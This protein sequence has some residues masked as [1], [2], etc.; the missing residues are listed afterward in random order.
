MKKKVGEDSASDP[1]VSP[2]KRE[3][4][5]SVSWKSAGLVWIA[6]FLFAL[7]WQ[8]QSGAWKSDFGGHA[9]EAAHVVT[10]LMVRDYLAGGFLEEWHPMRFA[11]AYYERFPKVAIGH[12]P[13]GFYVIEAL[14][15]LP[16]RQPAAL[17]VLM[18]ALAASVGWQTWRLARD[19]GIDEW[20]A[21]ALGLLLIWLPLVRTYTAIVMSDLLLV[22]LILAATRAFAR[23]LEAERWRDSWMFGLLAA[24]AILTKGSG[25]LLALVPPLAIAFSGRWSLLKSPRLWVAPV[26]VLLLAFPWM[27]ATRHI[28]EEGMSAIPFREYVSSALAS[29]FPGIVHEMGWLATALAVMALLSLAGRRNRVEIESATLWALVI[30]LLMF[31]LAIPSG[32]DLRYLL[33]LLPPLLVLAGSCLQRLGGRAFPRAKTWAVFALVL[34]VVWEVRRP[35]EKRYV[36]AAAAVERLL[37]ANSEAERTDVLVVS[38]ASG[39]G[40]ITAAA[41]FRAPHR[42]RVDRGSK[43]LAASDWLGRGYEKKFEDAE[44]LRTILRER[45]T[46]FVI[47]EKVPEAEAADSLPAHWTRLAQMLEEEAESV[48]AVLVDTL[49]LGRKN[50]P[51]SALLLYRIAV[52]RENLTEPRIPAAATRIAPS[53]PGAGRD[54]PVR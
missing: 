2:G 24:G 43:Q 30:G 29:Y 40:A 33:P 32:L 4:L 46:D 39:E 35:V 42:I 10:G 5:S 37:E 52:P 41:A 45:E 28:T 25:L 48:D 19:Q 8:I 53:P 36:G 1:P 34:V 6:F 49:P 3:S 11:E 7:A 23:F 16:F 26:P 17:L 22:I 44:S 47:L 18:A 13:P 9:D 21:I 14:F 51:E 54:D 12:Y 50:R 38:D 27:L 31:Y 15:L 20:G